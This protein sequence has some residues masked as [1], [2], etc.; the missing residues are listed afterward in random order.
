MIIYMLIILIAWFIST[1]NGVVLGVLS[2][3][4]FNRGKLK[5]NDI[6]WVMKIM[7]FGIFIFYYL[8]WKYRKELKK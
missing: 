8:Q 5:Y 3:D 2:M 7:F 1:A 6:F 4:R